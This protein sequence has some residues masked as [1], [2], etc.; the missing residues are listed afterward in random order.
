MRK[1]TKKQLAE[2]E[3]TRNAVDHQAKL[4]GDGFLQMALGLV[5]KTPP[6]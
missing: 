2:W 5:G 6:K 1:M 3:K 4:L